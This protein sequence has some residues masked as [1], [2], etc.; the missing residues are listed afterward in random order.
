MVFNDTYYS[1]ELFGVCFVQKKVAKACI[2]GDSSLNVRLAILIYNW[3]VEY[4]Y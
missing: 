3:V 1:K 2:F 4:V